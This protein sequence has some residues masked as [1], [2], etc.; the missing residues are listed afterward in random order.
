MGTIGKDLRDLFDG[1]TTLGQ[2]AVNIAD[3]PVSKFWGNFNPFAKSILETAYGKRTFP[4]AL[5]PIP[6][7]DK[8]RFIAQSFGF[9]WYYDWLTDKPHRA[10][11]DFGSSIANAEKPDRSAY[12]YILSRKRQF[13][14]NV[15]GKYSDTFTQTKRGEALRNARKAADFGDRKGVRKY[16][17]EFYKAGGTDEGLK[18]SG[19]AMSPLYG[20]NEDNQLRFLKWL[21]KD[22]RKIL[23][24]ALIY[25]EKLKA[26]LGL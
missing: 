25:S 21:P 26:Q 3:G 13:E 4:S 17:W 11:T 24:R 10:F 15:L 7:R 2:L 9:D 14:E 6:I 1:R 16:L 20:L 5:H 12:F 22:E 19:R 23:R 8:S 18:A